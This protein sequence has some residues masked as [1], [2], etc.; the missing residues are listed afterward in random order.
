MAWEERRSCL[1]IFR[2]INRDRI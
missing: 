1:N 2:V